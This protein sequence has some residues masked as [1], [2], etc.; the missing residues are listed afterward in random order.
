MTSR[1][2]LPPGS[3]EVQSIRPRLETPIMLILVIAGT[4]AIFQR[5]WDRAKVFMERPVT[6]LLARALSEGRVN[7]ARPLSVSE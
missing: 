2:L 4:K 3:A 6:R 5:F 7:G 1:L